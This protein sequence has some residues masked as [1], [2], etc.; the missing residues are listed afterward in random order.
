MIQS[1][2]VT[3]VD[4]FFFVWHCDVHYTNKLCFVNS[5]FCTGAELTE[6]RHGIFIETPLLVGLL[7]ECNPTIGSS[8]V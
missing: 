1:Y 2:L 6:D 7:L 3:V 8:Q 5:Q 4:S